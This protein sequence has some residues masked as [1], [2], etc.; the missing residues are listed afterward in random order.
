M[1]LTIKIKHNENFDSE[2]SKAFQIA[3]F[4]IQN[5]GVIT[6]KAVA[7]YGLKSMIS[8][9]ILRKYGRN[10]KCKNVKSVN[11]CIPQSRN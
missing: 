10:K 3:Q 8:N 9:Q 5:K 7:H 11:L 6:S 2:L 4:S 1:I